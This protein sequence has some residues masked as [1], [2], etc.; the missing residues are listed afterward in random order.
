MSLQLVSIL[1]SIAFHEFVGNTKTWLNKAGTNL[2]GGRLGFRFS[3]TPCNL[4]A[5]RTF[6]ILYIIPEATFYAKHAYGISF[7]VQRFVY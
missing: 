4:F 6:S 5:C 3:N 7:E 1:S 2:Y